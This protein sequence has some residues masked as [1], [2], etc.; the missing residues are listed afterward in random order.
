M[1]G[2]DQAQG[3]LVG[4]QSEVGVHLQDGSGD[5]GGDGAEE[6]LLDDLGLVLAG[7]DQQDLAGV[8]DGADAHGVGLTGHIVL[9][10][11]EALVGLDGLLGQI[12]A[13]GAHGEVIG[14]LVEAD[15]AVVADAQQL[16]IHAADSLDDGIV[17][18]AGGLGIGILTV[19]NVDGIGTDIHMV[20][21]VLVHEVPVALVVG[22]GQAAVL[23][24]VDGGDLSEAQIAD[25]VP[26]LDQAL[27]G[28]D[29]G[30]AGGQTQNAVGLGDDLGSDDV[31]GLAGHLSV[32]LGFDDSHDKL[33]SFLK[34][35]N[36]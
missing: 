20:E 9:G 14:G 21:Q 30:A 6:G 35:L 5:L 8:H 16:Q 18:S 29:G 27:V 7:G 1:F 12:D 22:A 32:V 25:L 31:G 2:S 34:F 15:V 19:G 24:Q 33:C 23:V 13:V 17:L 28:A 26:V 36:G 4:H 11:E 3:S 10:G